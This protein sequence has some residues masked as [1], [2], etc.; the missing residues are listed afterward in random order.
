MGSDGER[1]G[2]GVGLSSGHEEVPWVRG[3]PAEKNREMAG[4]L[5]L[6]G[7]NSRRRRTYPRQRR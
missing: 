2:D 7:D 3:V 4:E 5:G 1:E 6:D